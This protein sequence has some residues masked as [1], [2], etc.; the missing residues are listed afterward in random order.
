MAKSPTTAPGGEIG[1]QIS[2]KAMGFD[3]ETLVRMTMDAKEVDHFLMRVVGMA[4]GLKP[5][6][7]KQEGDRQGEVMYGLLGQFEATSVDGETKVGSVCYLPGYVN[8]M[9]VAALSMPDTEAVQIA[10]DIY[11]RYDATSA[12]MYVFVARDLLNNQQSGVAEVKEQLKA[13]PMPAAQLAL[14][15]A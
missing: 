13:I 3:K 5:Y 4:S 9:I 11:A 8:D 7:N 1:R 12:T 6:K 2:P 15:S 10:F 14:P